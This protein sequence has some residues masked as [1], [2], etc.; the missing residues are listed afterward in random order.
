MKLKVAYGYRGKCSRQ[1][2]VQRPWGE[3][4]EAC[5]S[6]EWQ[7]ARK[8]S[9][10]WERCAGPTTEVLA[11]RQDTTVESNGMTRPDTFQKNRSGCCEGCCE[12]CR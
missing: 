10:R 1:K 5:V 2:S 11:D 12:E 8:T 6:Q 7:K 9:G 4:E 3:L